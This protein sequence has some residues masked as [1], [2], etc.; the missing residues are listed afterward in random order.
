MQDQISE[1]QERLQ[2][3]E[4]DNGDIAKKIE[5]QREVITKRE[6]E[7]DDL[8]GKIEHGSGHGEDLRHVLDKLALEEKLLIEE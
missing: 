4:D 3:Q 8:R 2:M 7:I 1:M 5:T 6:E